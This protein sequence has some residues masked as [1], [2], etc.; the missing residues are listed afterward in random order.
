MQLWNNQLELT[1]AFDLASLGGISKIVQ[2]VYWDEPNHKILA[3]SWSAEIYEMHDQEGYDL[4]DGPLVQGHYEHRVFGLAV[5]PLGSAGICHCWRGPHGAHSGMRQ[6]TA[7]SRW[8]TSTMAHCV[9]RSPD[10]DFLAVGLGYA[11][12]GFGPNA[13]RQ[14]K[15]GAFVILTK[16]DLTIV[17]EARDSKQVISVIAFSPDGSTLAVG[18]NDRSIYLYNAGDWASTAKCRGHKGRITHIDFSTDSRFLQSTCDMG[19]LLFWETDSGEQRTAR[20]MKDTTWETKQLY[21]WPLQNAHGQ[22]D[23]GMALH[24][25][26]RSAG[27]SLATVDGF[28]R[29]RLW[30]YPCRSKSKLRGVPRARGRM[31]VAFVIDDSYLITIETIVASWWRH[32]EGHPDEPVTEDELVGPQTFD[33]KDTCMTGDRRPRLRMSTIDEDIFHGGAC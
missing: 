17:H 21:G 20:T 7:S 9:V 5:N 6:V 14:R 22:Y 4:H 31:A 18:S 3:A 25:S 16:K 1:T 27:T 2:S 26:Y 11:P 30:R 13:K 29:L 19:E 24:C 12:R 23:D 28:G 32:G 10:G 33:L 8:Q 15:D